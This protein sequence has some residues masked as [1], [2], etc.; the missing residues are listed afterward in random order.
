MLENTIF[1][2]INST[3]VEIQ[4]T[5]S[6]KTK[7]LNSYEKA[8]AIAGMLSAGILIPDGL[9]N[10]CNYHAF[11]AFKNPSLVYNSFRIVIANTLHRTIDGFL[12]A[13]GGQTWRLFGCASI[14]LGI[15]GLAFRHYEQSYGQMDQI[16]SIENSKQVCRFSP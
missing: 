12:D 1:N 8:S 6:D 14:A 7:N 16:P 11:T 10:A 9:N 2:K 5:V 4:Q 15:A 3:L 13:T